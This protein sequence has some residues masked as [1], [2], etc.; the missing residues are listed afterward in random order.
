MEHSYIGNKLMNGV[1]RLIMPKGDWY[2]NRLVWAGDYA[3]DETDRDC[4]LYTIMEEEGEEI[5]LVDTKKRPKAYKF[6]VNYTLKEFVDLSTIKEDEDGFKIHPLS[7]LVCEGN[8]RGGGDYL[9]GYD[10]DKGKVKEER[11]GSWAR[12]EI[13][14]EKEVKEGF[15]EINGQFKNNY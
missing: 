6:L 5:K 3:D 2:K 15:E 7:L 11:V 14:L 4:N 8:G 13:G 12:C 9:Y 10:E 1:E